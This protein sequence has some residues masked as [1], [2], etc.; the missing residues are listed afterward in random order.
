MHTFFFI[1]WEKSIH[2]LPSNFSISFKKRSSLK[3]L[4]HTMSHICFF[5]QSNLKLRG[6]LTCCLWILRANLRVFFGAIM[7]LRLIGIQ[8]CMWWHLFFH[9]PPSL[10]SIFFY[11]FQ[12]IHSSH[13]VSYI[14]IELLGIWNLSSISFYILLCVFF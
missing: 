12:R 9:G 4:E 11:I 3:G 7:V 13:C 5:L 6:S 8:L 14:S 1:S 10:E 2:H